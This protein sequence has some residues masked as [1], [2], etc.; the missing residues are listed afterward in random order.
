MKAAM[1]TKM[2]IAL[3]LLLFALSNPFGEEDQAGK[4]D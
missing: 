2:G 3:L 1:N 4:A